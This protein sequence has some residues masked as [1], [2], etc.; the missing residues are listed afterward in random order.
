MRPSSGD[1]EVASWRFH[2]FK[3]VVYGFLAMYT[4]WSPGYRVEPFRVDVLIALLARPKATFWNTTEG[5]AGVLELVVFTVKI[6][7]REC[8]S[9][10]CLDLLQLI[11]ASLNRDPITLACQ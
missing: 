7:N 8:A 4:K 6:R 5:R 1:E 3:I 10:C 9:R 2:L 11:G